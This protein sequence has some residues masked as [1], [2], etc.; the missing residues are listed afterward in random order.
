MSRGREAASGLV[1]RGGG[2]VWAEHLDGYPR[3][4]L[5]TQRL[6]SS[7]VAKLLSRCSGADER[8]IL[9][10]GTMTESNAFAL[11]AKTLAEED[12]WGR[13][14]PEE[15]SRGKSLDEELGCLQWE[16]GRGRGQ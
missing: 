15:E 5:G 14:E 11:P 8:S 1:H 16:F 9:V 13:A 4:I 2:K 6:L 3:R 12:A 10:L 7:V